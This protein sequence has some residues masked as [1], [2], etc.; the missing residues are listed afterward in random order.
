M[1]KQEIRKLFVIASAIDARMSPVD[2]DTYELKVAG[3]DLALDKTM[4]FE[5]AR[6]AVGN[7]YAY[8]NDAVMPAHLNHQW[9]KELKR[10]W[11][12]ESARLA[13]REIESARS[14]AVPMPEYLREQI[15]AMWRVPAEPVKE[16]ALDTITDRER[17]QEASKKWLENYG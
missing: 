2:S 1:N 11:L 17:K 10:L 7:H 16:L 15:E 6:A 14:D 3:W 9:T 5:F 8:S 4:P 12:E 13:T